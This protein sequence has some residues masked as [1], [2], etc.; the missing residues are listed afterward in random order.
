MISIRNNYFL[1]VESYVAE[2]L[3]ETLADSNTTGDPKLIL[4]PDTVP[5]TAVP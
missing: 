5:T 3:F 1:L 2:I 4:V